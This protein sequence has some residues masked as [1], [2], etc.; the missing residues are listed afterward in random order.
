MVV[1]KQ[2][3]ESRAGVKACRPTH[4]RDHTYLYPFA[5]GRCPAHVVVGVVSVLRQKWL[6]KD[7]LLLSHNCCHFQPK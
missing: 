1:R 6:A 4:N 5:V 3:M 2:R 7:Y